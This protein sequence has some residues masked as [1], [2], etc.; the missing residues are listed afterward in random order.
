MIATT[1][2]GLTAIANIIVGILDIF[3]FGSLMAAFNS[4]G[5]IARY[6]GQKKGV[7]F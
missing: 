1:V 5:A 3:V 2:L 6:I 7:L 4:F